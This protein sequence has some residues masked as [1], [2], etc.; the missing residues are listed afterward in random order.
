MIS[1]KLV[2]FQDGVTCYSQL[3]S[4]K[5]S[6]L[7]ITYEFTGGNIYGIISDF[8][9]GSWGLST[10]V[11]GRC[12][13][14]DGEVILNGK[15]INCQELSKYSCFIAE[16]QVNDINSAD[17]LLTAKD[18]IEKALHISQ[19]SYSAQDIKKMFGLSDERFERNLKEVSGEIWRISTAIGFASGKQIFCFPWLNEHEILRVNKPNLE[20]LRQHNK[21]ILIPS[22]QEKFLSKLCDHLIIFGKGKIAFKN[23][24]FF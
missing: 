11:G 19:L 9:C 22:S 16:S 2:N 6:F 18:C 17:D 8:G 1:I 7:K 3:H 14:Y 4:S 5:D 24:R 21:I 13:D 12:S 23:K 10:C 15:P 20:I